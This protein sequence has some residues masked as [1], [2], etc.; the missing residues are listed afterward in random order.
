MFFFYTDHVT[1]TGFYI[2]TPMSLG[3]WLKSFRIHSL[4]LTP[5]KNSMCL[6]FW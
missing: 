3:Q 6:S 1:L 4:P 5:S 2:V